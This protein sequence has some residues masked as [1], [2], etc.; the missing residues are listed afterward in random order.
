VGQ[1]FRV[2]H[3]SSVG[4]G[5]HGRH[6]L[7]ESGTAEPGTMESRLAGSNGGLACRS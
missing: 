5:S 1:V 4:H 6:V 7:D 3:A 2:D